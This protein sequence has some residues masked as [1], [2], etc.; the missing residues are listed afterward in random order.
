MHR[1]INL[2]HKDFA[3]SIR[4]N[5]LVYALVAP[6]VMAFLLR[7][8]LPT[9]T[10]M[11][12]NLVLTKDDAQPGFVAQLEKY[13]DVEIVPD[14]AAMEERVL[15][16]DDA[17]GVLVTGEN[18]YALILEG[19]ES[20]DAGELPGI[21]LERIA[22][23]ERQDYAVEEIN[24]D[25]MPAAQV[26]GVFLALGCMLIGGVLMAFNL[27]EEKET[28]SLQALEVTPLSRAEFIAG[29]SGI[30][31]LTSV[32]LVFGCLWLLGVD[33]FNVLQVL[34]VT[35]SGTLLAVIFGFIVGSVSANQTA[36]IANFKIGALLFVLVPVLTYI[37]PEG[38]KFLLYPVPTFWTFEAYRAVLVEAAPWGKVGVLAGIN[39]AVNVLFLAAVYPFLKKRLGFAAR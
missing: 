14:R 28:G 38:F 21:V 5:I 31:L 33:N 11:S 27:I 22:A 16:F 18:R 32:V 29:R 4:D 23:G 10:G 30:T 2:I 9:A 8:F 39:L 6:L 15:A 12:L 25:Y 19:N 37:I 35:L 3:N 20:R 7:L 36:G 26:T 1:V 13:V 24:P 17:V 34:V